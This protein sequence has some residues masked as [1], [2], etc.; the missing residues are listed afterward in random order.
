MDKDFLTSTQVAVLL[1]ISEATLNFWYR[2]KRTYPD[3]EYA[4]ILPDYIQATERQKRLWNRQDI[5]KLIEFKNAIPKG[6]NGIMGT[7]TQRYIKIKKEKNNGQRRKNDSR[8]TGSSVRG[9]EHKMQRTQKSSS[10]PK[11]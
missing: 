6:R 5:W 10:R 8:R 11:R 1:D 7:V 3:N 4:K 9:G 2:F